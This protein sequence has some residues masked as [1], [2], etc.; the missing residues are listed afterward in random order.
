MKYNV[1]I[2]GSEHILDIRKPIANDFDAYVAFIKQ[3]ATETNF[4]Y[5]YP[6]EPEPNRENQI[7][8]WESKYRH[9]M[10]VFDGDNMVGYFCLYVTN[11]KHPYLGHNGGHHTYILQKYT[12]N[13]LGSFFLKDLDVIARNLGIKRISINVHA[14]NGINLRILQKHGFTIESIAKRRYF[15]NNKYIDAVN[16]VK[17]ID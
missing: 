17:W 11:P 4:T 6:N 8:L 2:N 7:H 10:A 12:G 14:D 5:H 9:T 13:G 16:L 3:I 15:V 1:L